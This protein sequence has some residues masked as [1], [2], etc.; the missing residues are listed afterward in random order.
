VEVLM[1]H[2]SQTDEAYDRLGGY[3]VMNPPIRDERHLRAAW[4][5]VADGTWTWWAAT[6]RRIPARRRRGPGPTARRG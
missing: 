1:N 3:A 2:L 4:A 5:A 6:T